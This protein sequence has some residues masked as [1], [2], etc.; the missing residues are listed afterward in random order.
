MGGA[1][2]FVCGR[3]RMIA[4]HYSDAFLN[5]NRDSRKGESGMTDEDRQ[6]LVARFRAHEVVMWTDIDLAADEIERLAAL[7]QSD[8]RSRRNV[9]MALDRVCH[10][11]ENNRDDHV[12]LITVDALDALVDALAQ[13]DA[14]PQN[15]ELDDCPELLSERDGWGCVKSGSPGEWVSLEENERLK[16]ELAAAEAALRNT[17]LHYKVSDV[18][19]LDPKEKME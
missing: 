6:K 19:F 5:L 18:H 11:A 15:V 12:Y 8:A 16:K 2:S 17:L 7:V 3:L 14:E 10:D 1:I 4:D 9:R 13:S